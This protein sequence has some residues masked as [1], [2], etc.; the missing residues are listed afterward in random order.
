MR[1]P[2][3]AHTRTHTAHSTAQGGPPSSCCSCSLRCCSSMPKAGSG[4]VVASPEVSLACRLALT[5]FAHDSRASQSAVKTKSTQNHNRSQVVGKCALGL[6]G[7]GYVA[8]TNS[9][10]NHYSRA[11]SSCKE[12]FTYAF[13]PVFGSCMRA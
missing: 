9:E 8:L 6:R 12:E 5:D 1:A 13:T 4:E 2:A 3:R 7:G 10:Q 11:F